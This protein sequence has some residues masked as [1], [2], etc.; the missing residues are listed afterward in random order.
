[1]HATAFKRPQAEPASRR[2]C[3]GNGPDEPR[4]PPLVRRDDVAEHQPQQQHSATH[5]VG[6]KNGRRGRFLCPALKAGQ[7]T[8]NQIAAVEHQEHEGHKQITCTS[9][10]PDHCY[11]RMATQNGRAAQ[12]D[13]PKNRPLDVVAEQDKVA[14]WSLT[15]QMAEDTP[16]KT[17]RVTKKSRASAAEYPDSCGRV[18]RTQ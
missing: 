3:E 17:A 16:G 7:P 6:Q 12:Q 4:Q 10:Q 1:M 5:R 14:V 13:S 15:E 11:T 18:H 8:P 9:R 2:A